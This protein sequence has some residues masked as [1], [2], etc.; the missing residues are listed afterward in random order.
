MANQT[1][2]G[3]PIIWGR[4]T[5]YRV[6]ARTSGERVFQVLAAIFL[7][8]VTIGGL[9]AA[10]GL[11]IYIGSGVSDVQGLSD[12]KASAVEG[13]RTVSA[14]REALLPEPSIVARTG[15]TEVSR[16]SWI[17]CHLQGIGQGLGT[18]NY[19][20]VCYLTQN[21]YLDAGRATAEQLPWSAGGISP[22]GCRQD[23]HVK[24]VE[25]SII[26]YPADCAR[27]PIPSD[28]MAVEGATPGLGSSV[29]SVRSSYHFTYD[30]G[31]KPFSLSCDEPVPEPIRI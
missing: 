21:I 10:L 11:V 5:F 13:L 24:G 27:E 20:Q 18:T 17:T 2:L 7:V 1:S 9:I 31:C 3:G 30:L 29:V 28:A 14:Q 22:R 15:L 19:V 6:P 8:P 4:P 12:K 23:I 26:L 25:E 16:T